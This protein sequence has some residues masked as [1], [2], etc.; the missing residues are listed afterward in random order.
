MAG[1]TITCAWAGY[2]TLQPLLFPALPLLNLCSASLSIHQSSH[3][4][5]LKYYRWQ[6]IYIF[7]LEGIL[8]WFWG[9]FFSDFTFILHWNKTP[10]SQNSCHKGMSDK[11]CVTMLF[12]KEIEVSG[13]PDWKIGGGLL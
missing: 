9:V 4:L 13:W 2:D 1:K 11:C 7:Y 6:E 5:G 3:P 12:K 10:N 8:W